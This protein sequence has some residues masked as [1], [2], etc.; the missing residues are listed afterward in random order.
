LPNDNEFDR[1]F[2]E[3]VRRASDFHWTS[4]E[5]CREAAKWLVTGPG[6]RVLD[7][8]CGPGKFCAIGAMTTP[9]HFTGVE[10]RRHLCRAARDMIK[11]Y[12]IKRAQ[13]LHANVTEVAFN[14][15]DA[16][17]L[18]NPFEEN[19]IPALKIDDDVPVY[20]ELYDRYI[21]HV[22]RELSKLRIGTRVAT[23]WGDCDEIPTCYEC[24]ETAAN[25]ELRLW[26]HRGAGS[27]D[28]AAREAAKL[29]ETFEFAITEHTT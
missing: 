13:I 6:T 18:F 22:R 5:V 26:I 4:V 20:F 19:L 27:P 14:C 11:H 25:G 21:N 24:V 7:I 8:G 16:F 3:S 28:I 17:Y 1:V 12:R 10:Q 23:F 15:F 29:P 2:P 9:G